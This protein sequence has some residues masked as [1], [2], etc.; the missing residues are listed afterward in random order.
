[1]FVH[2]MALMQDEI[3]HWIESHMQ[4]DMQSKLTL[5]TFCKLC[6]RKYL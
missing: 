6:Q 2:L 3:T 5:F 4:V 1:M